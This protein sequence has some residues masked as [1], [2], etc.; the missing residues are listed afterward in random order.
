NV[1]NDF[2]YLPEVGR[3]INADVRYMLWIL[4]RVEKAEALLGELGVR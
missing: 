2:S 4:E 3:N 1:S